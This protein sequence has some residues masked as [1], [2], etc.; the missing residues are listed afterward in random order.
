MEKMTGVPAGKILGKGNY[1]Y[2]IPFYH[3]RRPILIDLVLSDDPAIDARYPYVKRDGKNLVSEITIPHFNEGRGAALWFTSSLLYDTGGTV[4]GAIESIREITEWKR[5]EDALNESEQK[6]RTV[7]ETT[8]TATILIENDATMSLVNSEFARLSGYR[9]DEIENRKKWTEF[10]VQ[11]DLDRML[12]QHKLRRQNRQDALTHYEFRFLTRS[13]EVRDIYLT[14]DVIPGTTKSVASLLDISDRKKVESSLVAAGHEFTNLLDQIQDIYYRSNAEGRLIRGSRSLSTLLG[15]DDLSECIGLSIADDFYLNPDDRK[16]FLEAIAREGKVTD[17]EVLL[18]RKDG[19]PVLVSTSSHVNVDAT[20][21]VLGVEGTFRDITE[22]KRQE[23]ILRTQRD[24]GLALLTVHGMSETLDVCLKAAIEISGTDAGG[25]YRVDE[26]TG[27]IDLLISRNLTDGFVA[28]VSHFPADSVNA[29]IINAGRPLYVRYSELD[30]THTPGQVLEGLRGS[31]VIPI[32]SGRR[33]TACLN[34]ASHTLGEI[35]Q[36]ARFALETIATQIGAAVERVRA[37]QALQ[38]SEQRYRNV[39]EDQTE[40]ISRFLPDGTHVFVNEA[41][42]RYFGRKRD[43]ILGHRFR[44]EIPA[45]DRIRTDLFFKTLTPDHPV[46]IIEHRIVLPDGSIRWQ[47]W[48]DRAIFDPGGNITEYQ[49]VGRDITDRKETEEALRESERQFRLLAENSQDVIERHSADARCI[50]ISPACRTLLGYDPEEIIGHPMTMILHPEDIPVIVKLRKSVSR[51][52]PSAKVSFRIRHKDG[53]YIWFESV[54]RGLFDGKSGELLEIFSI[55]RDITEQKRT[56]DALRQKSEDLD[57]RNRLISTLLDTVPIGIFMVEAPSGKPIIAN[58]EATRLLGRGIL[59][60]ATEENLAEVYEAYKASTS[61]RYPTDEMPIVRGMYGEHRHIDDMVVVRPDGTTAQ[62]EVFGNPIIDSQGR[63]T[64]SLVSFLDI[65]ERKR[66]EEA[67]RIAREK[68]T[69]VFHAVPDAIT[70][71]SLDSG[72]FVE[73][74]E[75]ATV[76]FGYSREELI[77][78]SASEL[79]IWRDPQNRAD[80]IDQ[81]MRLGRVNE[82]EV[83]EKRK[84][85]ELYHAAITADTLTLDGE[86]FILSVIR[87]VTGRKRAELVIREANRKINLLTSITRHDVANQISIIRGFANIALMKK[88]DPEITGLLKKIDTAISAIARQIEFT[89]EYQELGMHAPD[90]QSIRDIV[91]QQNAEGI[92][93]SCTCDAE[94]YADPMLERVF[95]NLVDNAA[96]HGEKITAITVSCRPDPD[97]LVIVVGD[98]G[99][100]VPNTLKEKIFEKGYGKHTG[101]G[102]FLAREILAITGII[103]IETGTPGKGA[104]FEIIVP[105]GTFRFGS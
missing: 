24:L 39:V 95:F 73:V 84:S 32:S 17:Y 15:Y 4:V 85:G 97:G 65:T 83:V 87:D 55:N 6:Y 49:S 34:I 1:E 62:L 103:I 52:N 61:R 88:P 9:K 76:L 105:K 53:H 44:P 59:P 75:A 56:E 93:V 26:K 60:D 70:V 23:H 94:V 20:G 35:P 40:F 102:L 7:F 86:K 8:G 89:R 90:W 58:R 13:G 79:G 51:N 36:A 101:F 74:N 99:I 21:R 54:F 41:Y 91:A 11:E 100:G 43:E 45:E 25:I 82:F 10:V 33:I 31:A 29:R 78:K 37:D 69:K 81:L 12:S 80:F 47:H 64:A 72:R 2:A 27:S 77:G 57:S 46:D 71:S 63:V 30:V 14:I 42:C 67:L 22:R 66:A 48:S 16:P 19:T 50:Y 3:E 28:S 98:D 68:Y 92:T 5:T 18:K 38:E 96:R 104:Q